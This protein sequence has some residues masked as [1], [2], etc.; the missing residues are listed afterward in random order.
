MRLFV[1]R[2]FPSIFSLCCL[3]G[4][5][6]KFITLQVLCV[7]REQ[8]LP[9][10]VW[11]GLFTKGMHKMNGGK[12]KE[13][14]YK[15]TKKKSNKQINTPKKLFLHLFQVCDAV[16]GTSLPAASLTFCP[17]TEFRD[18]WSHLHHPRTSSLISSPVPAPP[19]WD[20][21]AAQVAL[22]AFFGFAARRGCSVLQGAGASLQFWGNLWELCGSRGIHCPRPLWRV[23]KS[24]LRGALDPFPGHWSRDY[25][26][27]QCS[28]LSGRF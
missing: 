21:L 1:Q 23:R 18:F 20:F 22:T 6:W 5:S 4:A 12:K 7:R 9:A 19:C 10:P 2:H 28:S 27:A 3:P 14:K 15:N 13:K 26:P 16:P 11:F 25:R 17:K 8:D 24:P